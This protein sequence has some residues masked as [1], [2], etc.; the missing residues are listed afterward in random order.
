MCLHY[1]ARNGDIAMV[2][3][4]LKHILSPSSSPALKQ[5]LNWRSNSGSSPLAFACEHEQRGVVELLLNR[6]ADV[7]IAGNLLQ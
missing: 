7:T 3:V 4:I 2:Q 1:A 6:G 5:V